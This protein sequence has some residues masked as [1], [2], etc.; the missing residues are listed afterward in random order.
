VTAMP[1]VALGEGGVG[2]AEEAL[3]KE[4]TKRPHG[5]GHGARF[6]LCRVV[7]L[8]QRRRACKREEP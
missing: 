7:R 5:A 2:T 6:R 8:G 3:E 4:D 1:G